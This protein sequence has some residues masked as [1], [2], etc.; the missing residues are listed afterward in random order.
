MLCV[1]RTFL[2]RLA[3]SAADRP[4]AFQGAKIV[5]LQ[6]NV[7]MMDEKKH[8][9]ASLT[10]KFQFPL[11]VFHLLLQALQP[12]QQ[13]L[14]GI[15]AGGVDGQVVVQVGEPFQ[16]G[17]LF[18]GQAAFLVDK[19]SFNQSVFFQFVDE[20]GLYMAMAAKLRHPDDIVSHDVG[21]FKVFLLGI[22]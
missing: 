4:A 21:F 8:E 7:G 22:G 2:F 14:D 18:D 9:E 13:V 1:A 5:L 15:D 17:Q 10:V 20:R 3:A 12:L 19:E 11:Q 6:Q 16:V